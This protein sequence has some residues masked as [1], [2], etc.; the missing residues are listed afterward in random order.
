[1]L[2]FVLLDYLIAT[3]DQV[4]ICS[5]HQRCP[6]DTNRKTFNLHAAIGSK[7]FSQNFVQNLIESDCRGKKERVIAQGYAEMRATSWEFHYSGLLEM[8]NAVSLLS[9]Y[10]IV[11]VSIFISQALGG[12]NRH[13]QWLRMSNADKAAP[14]EALPLPMTFP[15]ECGESSCKNLI[16]SYPIYCLAVVVRALCCLGLQMIFRVT[17]SSA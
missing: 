3:D 4:R 11:V 10:S 13:L 15:G 14:V 17:I 12:W 6:K 8:N 1:M 2:Y 9:A 16:S 5:Y 7:H